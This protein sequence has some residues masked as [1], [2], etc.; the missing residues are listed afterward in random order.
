MLVELDTAVERAQL[1]SAEARRELAELERRPLARS[2]PSTRRVSARRSSTTDEAQLKTVERRRRARCEAQID[3]KIV[4]A[5][6]AGRLGI[7]AVNLGQYLNARHDGHDARRRS[8][9]VYV[10]FS[11]PQQELGDVAVGTAGARDAG[12]RAAARTLDG[13]IGAIDPTVDPATRSLKLRASVP[14]QHEARC[15]P[16]CS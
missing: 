10:D 16:A 13:T 9:R 8:T 2:S 1:A 15:G 11:L 3:R 5:P 4:R 14:E 7:R 12:R 6:F